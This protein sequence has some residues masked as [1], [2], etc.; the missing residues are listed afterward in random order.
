M[1]WETVLREARALRVVSTLPA[2]NILVAQMLGSAEVFLP[3]GTGKKTTGVGL[4]SEENP[5]SLVHLPRAGPGRWRR[6]S[7]RAGAAVPGPESSPGP[8]GGLTH[9]REEQG[10]GKSCL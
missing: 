5:G 7:T 9:R 2:P 1:T 3:T 8:A 4:A 6:E 10:S